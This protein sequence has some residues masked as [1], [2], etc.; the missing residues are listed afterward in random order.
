MFSSLGCAELTIRLST[1]PYR[2]NKVLILL[3]IMLSYRYYYITGNIILYILLYNGKYYIT[4]NIIIDL[5]DRI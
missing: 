3:Q 4:N 5:L 1:L 2:R